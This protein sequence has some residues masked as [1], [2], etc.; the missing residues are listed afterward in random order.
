[1]E[2]REC[3]EGKRKVRERKCIFGELILVKKG[4]AIFQYCDK[5]PFLFWAGLIAYDRLRII[6]GG[7]IC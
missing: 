1:M 4:R 7:Q 2:E 3:G 6:K 5:F